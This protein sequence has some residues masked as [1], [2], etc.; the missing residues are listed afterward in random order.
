MKN[1]MIFAAFL[2]LLKINRLYFAT[3]LLSTAKCAY[4]K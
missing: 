2:A 4:N 3:F 1:A